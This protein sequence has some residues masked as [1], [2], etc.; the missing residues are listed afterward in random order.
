ML[1]VASQRPHKIL[2]GLVKH[3]ER[4]P[5]EPGVVQGSHGR[6]GVFL[7]RERDA[8]CEGCRRLQ[9]IAGPVHEQAEGVV[10]ATERRVRR[11]A[12]HK[13]P[14]RRVR[15]AAIPRSLPEIQPRFP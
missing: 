2:L 12:P 3:T 6:V 13:G 9:E 14:L 7:L 5:A 1:G 15:V 4:A 11:D 10:P 8:P